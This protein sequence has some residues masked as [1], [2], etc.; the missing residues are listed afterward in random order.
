MSTVRRTTKKRKHRPEILRMKRAARNLG[1]PW[2]EVTA[3]RDRL[4]AQELEERG[5]ADALHRA[6]AV[7]WG[8]EGAAPFWRGFFR[9]KFAKLIADGGDCTSV[10]GFD[11]FVGQHFRSGGEETNA[12]CV[13]NGWTCDDVWELLIEERPPLLDVI[14]HYEQAIRNVLGVTAPAATYDLT[15]TPF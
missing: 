7:Y 3:E 9:R 1:I 5:P 10:P 12:D 4:R 14:V 13:T 8:G 2:R 11:M 6:A 15:S